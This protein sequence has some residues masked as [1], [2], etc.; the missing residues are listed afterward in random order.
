MEEVAT[1]LNF[2][3]SILKKGRG[4]SP[5]SSVILL[6]KGKAC[7]EEESFEKKTQDGA[8][9]PDRLLLG[10]NC[11]NSS[12]GA[13]LF[14]RKKESGWTR[15][16]REER[17]E[18]FP[19]GKRC[20]PPDTRRKGSLSL[21]RVVEGRYPWDV[22]SFVQKKGRHGKEVLGASRTQGKK[23]L[24]ASW[25]GSGLKGRVYRNQT[26]RGK[27]AGSGLPLKPQ[28]EGFTSRT[29]CRYVKRRGEREAERGG[30]RKGAGGGEGIEM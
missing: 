1:R 2:S 4:L 16:G 3:R 22:R 7:Q 11:C 17:S 28:R 6:E 10:A 12:Q 25:R 29:L 9:S 27:T 18:S 19:S 14:K 8:S 30:L 5:R 20:A 13:D 15:E 24:G 21:S 23:G 26:S